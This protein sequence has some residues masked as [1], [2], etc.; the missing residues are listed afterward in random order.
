MQVWFSD[1]RI[2]AENPAATTKERRAAMGGRCPVVS[3]VER[4][5]VE[6]HVDS[7][8]TTLARRMVRKR[9]SSPCSFD[10]RLAVEG[11]PRRLAKVCLENDNRSRVVKD[12]QRVKHS[13][14]GEGWRSV[15]GNIIPQHAPL[16]SQAWSS[17]RRWWLCVEPTA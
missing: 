14:R 7:S 15:V 12:G 6:Q 9:Q 4:T 2:I 17:G 8:A 10:Q 16:V 5:R 1:R 13:D 3:A 11:R